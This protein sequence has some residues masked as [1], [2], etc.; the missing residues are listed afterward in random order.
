MNPSIISISEKLPPFSHEVEPGH[1]LQIEPFPL[2][3][4][5]VSADMD[6]TADHVEGL[7][8]DGGAVLDADPFEPDPAPQP[9]A[10]TLDTPLPDEHLPPEPE[11][12][13][14]FDLYGPPVYTKTVQSNQII[15]D[16]NEAYWAGRYRREN[17]I[18][19]EPDERTFYKYS[20]EHGLFS[21]ETPDRIKHD[22][23]A[24][25]LNES[26]APSMDDLIK[27]RKDSKLNSVVAT[28]RGITEERGAFEDRPQTVHLAN[29]FLRLNPQ[30]FESLPFSPQFKSRNQSPISY[31]P[32]SMCPRFLDELILP[33]VHPEDVFL[34]QKMIG[35]IL[36]GRNLVQRFVILDGLGGRGKTQLINILKLIVGII[37]ST[38]LRTHLLNERFEIFRFRKCTLL[39]GIDVPADFLSTKPAQ[40]IKGL[41]GGD[42]FDAEQKGG[43]GSFPIKGDFNIFIA[44]NARLKIKLDG[45]VSAWRR[46][47][48]IVRYEA[49]PPKK[50]IPN[51][52]ELLVD[53]EGSGIM[54]W[55]LEGIRMLM[56]DITSH[57]DITLTDRQK[58][59]VESLLAESES[60]RHFVETRIVSAPARNLTVDEIVEAYADFCPEMG[61][62]ALPITD[63]HSELPS[64]MLEKFRTVRANDIQRDGRAKR[65]FRNV[66]FIGESKT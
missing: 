52:A 50:K 58:G 34:L 14:L 24:M 2:T 48:L 66:A 21:V 47:L 3:R 61:W 26:H 16:I 51:F 60:L 40:V 1:T 13:S 54:N 17:I 4:A 33:A 31:D 37:N 8:M 19:H 9:Q 12:P 39:T 44:S 29:C 10:S 41:V 20:E 7:L 63:I 57:G 11:L 36:L 5:G 62:N 32:A 15:V 53:Q 35:Q 56:D 38:Q 49:P 30:G 45:D 22:L 27:F 64:L 18:L 23:S 28:L 42:W 46:R 6:Y 59:V 25:L 65:G 55:A 43:T